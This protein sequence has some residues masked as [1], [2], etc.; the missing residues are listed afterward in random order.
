[1]KRTDHSVYI[2]F[3]A[4]GLYDGYNNSNLLMY[5]GTYGNYWSSSYDSS[6]SA[7]YLSFNSYGVNPNVYY[8]R[9]NGC[10]VRA[11]IGPQDWLKDSYEES[12][13][14]EFYNSLQDSYYG[15]SGSTDYYHSD[16]P[17][18]MELAA[19][20]RGVNEYYSGKKEYTASDNVSITAT[21]MDI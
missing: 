14:V 8:Y 16:I 13:S 12:L 1:M 18:N 10:S 20:V 9:I 6:N 21:T 15:D 7:H 11:V 17:C 3:P 2:F 5:R 4:A 19:L